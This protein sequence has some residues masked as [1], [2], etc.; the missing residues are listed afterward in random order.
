MELVDCGSLDGG[1]GGGW[2]KGRSFLRCLGLSFFV[3]IRS[4]DMWEE[5]ERGSMAISMA[6]M[7]EMAIYRSR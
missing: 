2:E 4:G 5:G 6:E 3:F 1:G 7:A